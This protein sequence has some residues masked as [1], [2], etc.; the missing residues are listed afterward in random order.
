MKRNEKPN[1]KTAA[2][3]EWLRN[4]NKSKNYYKGQCDVLARTGTKSCSAKNR[5]RV[6]RVKR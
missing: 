3:C 2:N 1:D 4:K 6:N 5:L